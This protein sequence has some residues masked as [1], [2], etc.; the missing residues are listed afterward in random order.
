MAFTAFIWEA[1]MKT[2]INYFLNK[3]WVLKIITP[4]LSED[5]KEEIAIAQFRQELLFWGVAT[6]HLTNEELKE[7]VYNFGKM[8]TQTGFT[9]DEIS[10]AMKAIAQ[11][12][13]SNNSKIIR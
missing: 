8:I 9:T 7:L 13:K 11:F 6:C 12:D 10:N 5:K 1:E 4:F 3:S 2:F